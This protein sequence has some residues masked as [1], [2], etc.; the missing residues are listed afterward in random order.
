MK[1]F[2]SWSGT[3]SRGIASAIYDWIPIVLQ[4]AEPF[5]SSEEIDKGTRWSSTIAGELNKTNFG[6]IC[7]TPENLDAPWIHFEAGALS[8][9]VDHA[10]VAPILFGVKVSDV[11]GPLAQFHLTNF[12]K[13]D[14]R[15][16]VS[17]IN[18][19][20]GDE[21]IDEARLDKAYAALW[22][23][24]DA[25]VKKA[26]AGRK[27]VVPK[28]PP[29]PRE[30]ILEE[31]LLLGRQQFQFLTSPEFPTNLAK[32]LTDVFEDMRGYS[33]TLPAD[34]PV[35]SDLFEAW[36]AIREVIKKNETTADHE[37]MNKELMRRLEQL[38][39]I[40][41]YISR[42]FPP[43]ARPD[44]RRRLNR[45]RFDKT[46]DALTVPP[47]PPECPSG[48]FIRDCRVFAA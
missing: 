13:D 31:L 44:L 29:T 18:S 47:S 14:I 5:T 35:W 12:D 28:V 34:H 30:E 39:S 45:V 32:R 6:I 40:I 24:L 21:A 9:F 26:E 17:S 19:A 33:S 3:N 1:V 10:R 37:T 43:G 46:N 16:L 36:T 7:L 41:A 8:K 25:N 20:A 42:R 11:Q 22:P 23:D 27:T 38:G 2:I 48:D 4:Y 15:K